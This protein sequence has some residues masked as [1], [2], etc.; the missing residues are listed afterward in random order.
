MHALHTL[1]FFNFLTLRTKKQKKSKGRQCGL[2]ADQNTVQ[3]RHPTTG[4]TTGEAG[5]S[6]VEARPLRTSCK[7]VGTSHTRVSRTTSTNWRRCERAEGYSS[8]ACV[9][10]LTTRRGATSP[11][12]ASGRPTTLLLEPSSCRAPGK[13]PPLRRLHLLLHLHPRRPG[14]LL[15]PSWRCTF[16]E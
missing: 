11:S 15:R 3:D 2:G 9:R 12:A 4:H 5:K 16:I 10:P 7:P 6:E 13:N 8:A 1:K 14:G